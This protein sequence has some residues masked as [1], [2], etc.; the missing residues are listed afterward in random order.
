MH[1]HLF[2]PLLFVVGF[3][4]AYIAFNAVESMA[5]LTQC[6]PPMITL[7]LPC[8]HRIQNMVQLYN[9]LYTLFNNFQWHTYMSAF[10]LQMNYY[11][12]IIWGSVCMCLWLTYSFHS[13]CIQTSFPFNPFWY[14]KRKSFREAT[15]HM[16]AKWWIHF[17]L[18]FYIQLMVSQHLYFVSIRLRVS[19]TRPGY[20][21][22]TA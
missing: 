22:K 20:V 10:V 12:Y 8:L 4:L 11:Y 19:V 17:I 7:I 14:T 21:N 16:T 1:F 6:S 15:Q 9:F 2:T 3:F 5:T 13:D 18:S